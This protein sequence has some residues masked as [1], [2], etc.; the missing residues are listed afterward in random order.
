MTVFAPTDSAFYALP[1]KDFER[2]LNNKEES[3]K[4]LK[5]H[6]VAKG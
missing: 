6:I 1:K 4:V 5:K 3:L 2:I